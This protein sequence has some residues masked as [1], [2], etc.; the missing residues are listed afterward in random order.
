P[1]LTPGL[2]GGNTGSGATIIS[3]LFSHTSVTAQTATYTVVPSTADCGDGKSFTLVVTINPVADIQPL[4]TTVCGGI[5]F[6][7]SPVD[8]TSGRVPA[9]TRYTWLAPTGSGFTGGISQ[10]I[11]Q[12]FISGNLTNTVSTITTATYIV[13]PVTGSCT[14][15]TFTLQVELKPKA[16]I[17]PLSQTIC[18]GQTFGITP[19]NP[20][21]GI[22]PD[23]TSYTWATPTGTSLIGLLSQT[24]A[25]SQIFGTLTNTSNIARTATY[26]VTPLSG[27]CTGNIFSITVWV[28]PVVSISNFSRVVCSGT[29][30]NL[31]AINVTN[32][33]VPAN[34][35]YTWSSP[36]LSGTLSGSGS[37]GPASSIT[38]TLS[39]TN[40]VTQTAV[41][42]VIPSSSPCGAGGAFSLTLFVNPIPIISNS[43]TLT[44]CGGIPFVFTPTD[45][46]EG[47][48]PQ[49]TQYTWL[50]PTGTG[51]TG[52][53]SRTL[54]SNFTGQLSN[55]SSS[56]ATAT[57][58]VIPTAP[59]GCAGQAFTWVVSIVPN[60]FIAALST[61]TC[62]GIQFQYTP[63][64]G[65]IPTGTVYDWS[66]P[67]GG[68]LS[69]GAAGAGESIISGTLNNSS[70]ITRTA[71][72]TVTPVAG[73]CTGSSFTL[74]VFVQ[75]IAQINELSTTVCSG[76]SFSVSPANGGTTGVV[77]SG[78][79]Y[80]WLEPTGTAISG[81]FSQS[82]F[83]NAITGTL[84]NTSSSAKT[85][86]YIVS[87][88]SGNC[89]GQNF[90][91]VVTVLPKP[92]LGTL[93]T[94][95][96]TGFTF[97]LNPV[98]GTDGLI[99]VSTTFT[100]NAPTGAGITG[101]LTQSSGAGNITG[102]LFNATSTIVTATYRVLPTAAACAGDAFTVLVAVKPQPV[103]TPISTTICSG[104]T[105][106]ISP[107]TGTN[108][109]VPTGTLYR[110]WDGSTWL[111]PVAVISGTLNNATSTV[112]STTYLFEPTAN[113]CT[114][115]TF[116]VTIFVN[117][118][119]AVNAL[120]LSVCSG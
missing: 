46:A 101:G 25:V 33:I 107:V 86:L 24:T 73:S 13:T 99:P 90:T 111:P 9:G 63:V 61:T 115:Q 114:G 55:S 108:G 76:V 4:T 118:Q 77:P 35:Q 100:W 28:N 26:L 119:P 81:G 3:G 109:T 72:Y 89:N 2:S 47:I 1:S 113:G 60:A 104:A 8:P 105:Y 71:T 21:S 117:P 50:T 65:V 87:T 62:S 41:F 14:G 39:H 16:I 10:T 34:T 40:N 96:C 102:R 103:I 6:Q 29:A 5:T 98:D 85:A 110:Q 66:S 116:T 43:L 52:G 91:L 19:T 49:N 112:Q 83:V 97:T 31:S 93:T 57:Y 38:G 32:G 75:P 92:S 74:T 120:A 12:N 64:S 68:F 30:F 7:V 48:I 18:S 88:Q 69:G 95:I 23:L 44:V 59:G 51:F 36:E 54:S 42:S 79:L 17:N 15:L 56:G 80:S 82:T 78:T 53:A 94:D 37:G 70:N 27:D 58:T 45:G 20:A 67:S 11:Q 22:V 84:V 106:T